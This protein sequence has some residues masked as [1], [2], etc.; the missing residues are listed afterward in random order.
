[1]QKRARPIDLFCQEPFR[2]FFPVGLL[3]GVIGVSLWI[4]YYTGITAQYPGV[5]HARL[6]IEGFVASFVIGFLGTAG[7]RLTATP[8]FSR[9]ELFTLLTLDLLSAGLH[10]GGANHAGDAAFALCL[11]SF[12]F[13]LARR[14]IHRRD[15]PPPNF[16]LVGL[17]LVN[18]LA[19][20]VLL[21]LFENEAY[22]VPYRIGAALLQQGFPLLAILGVA[23]F[24]LPLLLNFSAS[25][26]LPRSRTF[27]MIWLARATLAAAIG[28]TI[29]VTFIIETLGLTSLG[30]WLRACALV[31]YLVAQTPRTGQSFLGN[32]LRLGLGAIAFGFIA[33]ALWPQLRM[34]ALHVVFITGFAF[35]ILTVAIRVILGHSGNSHLFTRRLPFHIVVATILALAMFSRFTADLAPRARA[36]HLV[37]AA[38]LW[39]IAILIWSLELVPKLTIVDTKV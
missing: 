8:H 30:A 17:S 25:D 27:S 4:V 12:L 19:G 35:V 7:P 5:A 10:L 31:V 32:C 37:A 38:I 29:D 9:T 11:S 24:V 39:L 21:A 2:V 20:A 26:N 13:V 1:M 3:L 23:P 33:E 6:M 22:S 18:A 16:L 36:A 14:F 28:L 34:G 15:S